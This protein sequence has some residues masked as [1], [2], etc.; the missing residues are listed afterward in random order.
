MRVAGAGAAHERAAEPI[1]DP[2][3]P[4]AWAGTFVLD[5]AHFKRGRKRLSADELA[6][7]VSHDD[8]QEYKREK[9]AA[10]KHLPGGVMIADILTKAPARVIYIDLL[11]LIDAYA[12]D[13]IACP[14]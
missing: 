3:P 12:S 8:V 4:E 7:L 10:L 6:R 11:R 9:A 2:V 14:T 1:D 13:G 5:P